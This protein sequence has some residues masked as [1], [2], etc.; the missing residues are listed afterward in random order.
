MKTLLRYFTS[1]GPSVASSVF[2][3]LVLGVANF[4]NASASSGPDTAHKG[5]SINRYTKLWTAKFFQQTALPKSAKPRP[6]APPPAAVCNYRL[7]GIAEIGGRKYVYLSDKGSGVLHELQ[8]NQPMGDLVVSKI[9]VGE[10]AAT[11]KVKIR[12]GGNSFDLKFDMVSS[13]SSQE[14]SKPSGDPLPDVTVG[15]GGDGRDEPEER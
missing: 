1:R 8:L 5:Y 14:T 6:S 10:Q 7:E 3:L 13:T 11:H 15:E 2:C 9:S 4:E 12:S